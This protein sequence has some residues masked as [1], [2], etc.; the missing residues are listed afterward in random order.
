LHAPSSA[1][2]DV[3]RQDSHMRRYEQV[4]G[5]FFALVA[6]VQLTR[7]LLGWRVQVTTVEVPIWASG[8]AFLITGGF[9]I[10][11]FRSARSVSGP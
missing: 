10:W 4:S 5:V 7:T 2:I 8:L 9:A 3:S 6:L 1:N 11:A